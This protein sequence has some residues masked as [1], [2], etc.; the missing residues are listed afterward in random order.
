M[1]KSKEKKSYD[2]WKLDS[3]MKYTSSLFY[4]PN[5]PE[6][7]SVIIKNEENIQSTKLSR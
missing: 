3:I 2:Y 7:L 4:Y 1:R 5:Y 6:E